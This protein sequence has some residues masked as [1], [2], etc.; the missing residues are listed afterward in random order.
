MKNIQR[1]LERGRVQIAGA[2]GRTDDLRRSNLSTIMRLVHAN[3]GPTR[4]FLTRETGLNR[5]TVGVCIGELVD[6]GLVYEA[7]PPPGRAGRPS[8]LVLP[9]ERVVSVTVNFEVDSMTVGVVGL[10]GQVL[11]R[12]RV[13]TGGPLGVDEVVSRSATMIRDL[14]EGR[15][16]LISAVGVGVP[17]QV[18]LADGVVRDAFHFGWEDEPLAA[19]LSEAVGIPVFAA[20]GG[21]LAMRSEIA[22]GAGRNVRDLVH[23]SGGDSGIGG[24]AISGGELLTGTGGYAGEFAHTFVR[25]NGRPC[26]CGANGCLEA[27]ITQQELLDAVGLSVVDTGKL[28]TTLSESSD[29]GIR[30]LVDE[31]LGYL[32]VAT[33][34]LTNIFNPSVIVLGGFLDA[35]YLARS[36][37]WNGGQRPIRVGQEAVRIVSAALGTDQLIIGTAE[38]A[39]SALLDDPL[40][41]PLT[42]TA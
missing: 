5:S 20:N 33:R 34:N 11:D 18:R 38:L 40:G 28:R 4:A 21:V 15:D 17:G 39:F 31:K 1:T 41:W 14:L 42:Q 36:D 8:P 6:R 25:S 10:G 12:E 24:G 22:F 13:E 7:A 32:A 2:G 35:L 19:S 37:G 23:L 29:P 9:D 26:Y 16:L 3:R 27:E 30:A